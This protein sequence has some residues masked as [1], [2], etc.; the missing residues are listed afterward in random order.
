MKNLNWC[1]YPYRHSRPFEYCVNTLI[2]DPDLKE[3]KGNSEKE[4]VG[5]TRIHVKNIRTKILLFERN[6]VYYILIL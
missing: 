1:I 5:S 4:A 2:H 6:I 3:E